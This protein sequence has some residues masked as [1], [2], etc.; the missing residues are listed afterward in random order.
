MKTSRNPRHASLVRLGALGLCLWTG[1]ATAQLPSFA[2]NSGLATIPWLFADGNTLVYDV[3][4]QQV[5]GGK[6]FNFTSA[7]STPPAALTVASGGSI[8][9]G[10]DQA[11][12]L[13]GTQTALRLIAVTEDS[14]CPIDAVCISAGQAKVVFSVWESG[15]HLRDITL[16][17]ATGTNSQILDNLRVTL[18]GLSPTPSSS[19]TL[20]SSAYS[21]KLDVAPQ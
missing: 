13:A 5:D 4:L 12:Y 10:M 18:S 21:A 11:I 16:S 7:A 6:T 19:T 9:V 8:T 1:V 15:K 14:R 17:T 20:S 3:Q 2:S